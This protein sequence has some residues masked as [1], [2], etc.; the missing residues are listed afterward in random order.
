MICVIAILLSKMC[1][2]ETLKL[3]VIRSVYTRG[4]LDVLTPEFKWKTSID[5]QV[6]IVGTAILG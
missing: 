1:C 4:P 6:L 2:A 3:A 5:V